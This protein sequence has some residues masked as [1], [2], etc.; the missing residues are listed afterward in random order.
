[1]DLTLTTSSTNLHLVSEP[2]YHTLK[3]ISNMSL[4]FTTLLL[5]MLTSLAQSCSLHRRHY[6]GPPQSLQD[7][8]NSSLTAQP[9]H[10]LLKRWY[11]VPALPTDGTRI[12]PPHYYPW[13]ATCGEPIIQPIRYCW[14]DERSQ[15]NLQAVLDTAIS[16]WV[17]T[18]HPVSSL[19]II[20]E[21]TCNGNVKCLCSDTGV[22]KDALMI[23]DETR[24][25]DDDWNLGPDCVTASTVGYRYI[26]DGQPEVPYRH[27]SM[28][29]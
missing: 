21:P 25:G 29:S 16:E 3:A 28:P 1:M 8:D 2:N 19:Q 13:P 24:D 4:R 10:E 18:F 15:K 12:K 7:F 14:K 22:A 27:Y 5:V 9:G 23:S 26:P 6:Y 11:G 17:H 20:L